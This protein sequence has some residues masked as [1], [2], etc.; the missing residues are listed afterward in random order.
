[1][2]IYLIRHGETD[3]NA[4]R[5]VQLPEAPLS[6]RGLEQ[7]GRLATRMSGTGVRAILASDFARAAMTAQRIAEA[8]G[9]PVEHD[10]VLHERNLG[11]LRGTSYAELAERG[12]DPFAPGYAP[13]AG[14]SPT[15]FE[16]RVYRAW[17]RIVER[18]SAVDGDL[19]VVTHGLVCRVIV[20]RHLGSDVDG[21]AAVAFAN[22]SVTEILG[23]PWRAI[24]IGCAAHLDGVAPEGGAA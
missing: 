19:A 21:N 4:N 6:Q 16:A 7:A 22:T 8:T 9:L 15:V 24:R 2:T 10:T 18:A 3:G 13:P 17:Q 5:V 11:D 1:M 14:E 23:P 20:T 12:I